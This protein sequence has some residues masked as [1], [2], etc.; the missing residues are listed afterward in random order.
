MSRR[1]SLEI[2]L[3]SLE[4]NIKQ[5]KCRLRTDLHKFQVVAFARPFGLLLRFLK[6][7][8]GHLQKYAGDLSNSD[9]KNYDGKG[10]LTHKVERDMSMH[11]VP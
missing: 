11:H 10:K 3:N 8:L 7:P 2:G 6:A 9:G 5:W 4:Y 1:V